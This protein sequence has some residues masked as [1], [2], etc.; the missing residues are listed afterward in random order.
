MSGNGAAMQIN[1]LEKFTKLYGRIDA[2]LIVNKENIIEYSAMVTEDK[3]YLQTDDILGKNLFT[4]Y[5]ELSE[6]NSTHAKVMATG[7]PVLNQKQTLTE[8]SGRRHTTMTSTFPIENNGEL[9]GSIDL[10]VELSDDADEISKKRKLYTADDIVTQNPD[11]EYMKEKLLK[12]AKNDSPVMVIGES[13]TGKELIVE[14]L[15]SHGRRKKKPFISLNCA[16]IPDA[17]IEST[18]FGTVKGSFTGAENKKGLFELADGGTLFLDE[19]NSMSLELQTKL[20]KAV[21]EQRYMKVG[22][23]SYTEVDTRLISAMN[24]CPKEVIENGKMRQDLFYRLSVVQLQVP[25]LRERKEDLTLLVSHFI[26]LYNKSMGKS[27]Q[28]ISPFAEKVLRDYN[29]PGNVRELR[30]VIE[31]AFNLVEGD[32]IGLPDLPDY[33]ISGSGMLGESNSAER[34]ELNG[35]LTEIMNRYEKEILEKTLKSAT[36]LNQAAEQLQITRQALKYKIEKLQID[37]QG[38]LKK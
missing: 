4:V 19:V 5:P 24:A 16:A 20:L 38:L 22:A 33:L 31:S 36:S 23:E 18:L 37:Y 21:E 34:T 1:S 35:S 25:P 10:S 8:P 32:V 12:I 17:L 6:H 13:G 15:H 27:V 26:G 11:M 28:G 29:W 2:I 7:L 3:A 9:I 14:A 30:N